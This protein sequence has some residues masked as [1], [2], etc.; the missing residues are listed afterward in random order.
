MIWVGYKVYAVESGGANVYMID[1][2]TD[3]IEDSI[4]VGWAP[5]SIRED[6][7]GKIWVI[8]YGAF[9]GSM[10]ATLT[11]IDPSDNGIEMQWDFPTGTPSDLEIN[12]A[13]DAVYFVNNDI[14]R[15]DITAT[16]LPGGPL[17]AADGR[18]LYGLGIDEE[19]N[20]IYVSDAIDFQQ[21][22]MIYRYAMD[23]NEVDNFTAGIIPGD[24]Y[25]VD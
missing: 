13:G 8:S 5:N 12:E 11:R 10:A 19:E 17:I 3:V 18:T 2:Y 15:M 6:Q 16:S 20:M 7:N 1:P 22:G 21:I 14:F 4:N 9:D 23:G 24:F 25:F